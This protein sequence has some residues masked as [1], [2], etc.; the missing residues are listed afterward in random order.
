VAG[1]K[2]QP[3]GNPVGHT[4]P[5]EGSSGSPA[6]RMDPGQDSFAEVEHTAHMGLRQVQGQQR[7][8]RQELRQRPCAHHRSHL[9]SC[10]NIYKK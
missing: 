2:G 5:L 9:Q 10:V 3:E 6:G 7:A 8:L 1:C 4:D